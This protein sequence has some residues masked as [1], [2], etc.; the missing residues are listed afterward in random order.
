MRSRADQRRHAGR[1][2]VPVPR[3]A[4]R[5]SAR[6]DRRRANARPT[7]S[8]AAGRISPTARAR[9]NGRS[10]GRC[11]PTAGLAIIATPSRPP[12][13]APTSRA[14]APRCAKG[15]RAFGE[16]VG[17]KKAKDI[18]AEDIMTGAEIMLSVFIRD[19]QFQSQTKDRLTS[20]EAARLVE[21]AVRDHF[22]HFLADNM[23]RGRALLGFVLDRMD[24]RLQAPRRAR[25]QAQDRD[26]RAASCGCPASSPTAPMT[27]RR[28]PN[29]SSSRA[30]APAARPSRRATARPRRSCR[31]AARS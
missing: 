3:R 6:A 1:G 4:R 11:G 10:P 7:T 19:P 27:I 20:P 14:C 28:A 18:Q 5:P 12:T 22:D 31:S 17:Q 24:E 23:E 30:T 8:S 16:L 26:Q 21:N 9:S 2:G 13:A 29:C 15:I 25:D